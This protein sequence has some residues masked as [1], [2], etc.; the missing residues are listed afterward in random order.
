VKLWETTVSN[1]VAPALAPLPG[2]GIAVLSHSSIT[3]YGPSGLLL[4]KEMR[5]GPRVDDLVTG[6][7]LYTTTGGDSG[8]LTAYDQ[9]GIAWKVAGLSGALAAADGSVYVLAS[10]GLYRVEAGGGETE[11]IKSLP[12]AS[13]GG[14]IIGLPGGRFLVLH[15]DLSDRRLLLFN[16]E[17][18]V[19]E[20]SV[21]EFVIGDGLLASVNGST[22]LVTGTATQYSQ[23]V[24]VYRID[25][26]GP[27]DLE[28]I[29]EGGTRRP[30]AGE[31][32]VGTTEDGALLLRFGEDTLV[33][34]EL[35]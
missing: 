4:W 34:I 10:E 18:L 7:Y 27:G 26:E 33:A 3:A 8:G 22:V 12:K 19:W 13:R 31:L 15:S 16:E 11:L 1:A 23:H 6:E 32:E 9:E 28:L 29:F 24:Y 30:D 14:E 25:L 21:R 35:P 17:G 2:G 5:P 20:R